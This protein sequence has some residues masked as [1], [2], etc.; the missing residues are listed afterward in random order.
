MAWFVRYIQNG[1]EWSTILTSA[2]PHPVAWAHARD[3]RAA[4]VELLF[5]A[6]IPRRIAVRVAAE[7]AAGNPNSIAPS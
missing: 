7:H 4:K 2:T 5:F 3:P 1:S 6:E